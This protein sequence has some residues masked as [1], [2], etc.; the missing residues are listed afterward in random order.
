MKQTS[1]RACRL[2]QRA[3]FF[4]RS[5]HIFHPI[6]E[7][8]ISARK[9][10]NYRLRQ[11]G[12]E[13]VGEA[14]NPAEGLALFRE[15][16]PQLVTLD[17]LMPEV[18]GMTSK[19]LFHS[20]RKD[21]PETVIIIVS[22]RPKGIERAEFIRDGA[23]AYFEKPFINFHSLVQRLEQLFPKIDSSSQA[24]ATRRL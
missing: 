16:N 10:L 11:I 12:C 2:R 13:V 20:I 6:I 8:S 18:D 1:R 19:D 4:R 3:F 23:F 15:L 7:D 9:L 22:A 17:I 5:L 24:G 14:V 21:S